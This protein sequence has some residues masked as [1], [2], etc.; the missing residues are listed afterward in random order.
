VP[1]WLRLSGRMVS[2]GED[3]G[4]GI[5]IIERTEDHILWEFAEAKPPTAAGESQCDIVTVH[6]PVGVD[7]LKAYLYAAAVK[8]QMPVG[9]WKQHFLTY[10]SKEK[11][12]FPTAALTP[13]KIQG[14]FQ[15]VKKERLAKE[16]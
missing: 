4:V 6:A 15:K 16:T 14:M 10:C 11:E 13:G 1:L 7:A 8:R 3:E 12:C 9:D 5:R 2:I